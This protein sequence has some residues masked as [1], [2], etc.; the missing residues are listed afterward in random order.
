[1]VLPLVWIGD[2][3]LTKPWLGLIPAIAFCLLNWHKRSRWLLMSGVFWLVY[4]IYEFAMFLRLICT[5]ECNI[6]VDLILIYP[7]LLFV[8]TVA[9]LIYAYLLTQQGRK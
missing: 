2:F 8:S 9:L 4:T 5:G 6:R 7:L 1:M 3:F